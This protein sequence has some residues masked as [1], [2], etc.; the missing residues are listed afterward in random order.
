MSLKQFLSVSVFIWKLCCHYVRVELT[1]SANLFLFKKNILSKSAF[2]ENKLTL[3]SQNT[4]LLNE[5]AIKSFDI[6][7]SFYNI[8]YG[9]IK[10]KFKYNFDNLKDFC[11]FIDEK[12][13]NFNLI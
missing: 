13:K 12:Y 5:S 3:I 11:A 1:F 6:I 10:I 8:Y 9:T 2:L 4:A 7:D